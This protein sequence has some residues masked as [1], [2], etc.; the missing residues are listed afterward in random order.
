MVKFRVKFRVTMRIRVSVKVKFKV[1]FE[2]LAIDNVS[3]C[4]IYL[5]R[6]VLVCVHLLKRLVCCPHIRRCR[7]HSRWCLLELPMKLENIGWR[8]EKIERCISSLSR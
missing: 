4:D 3:Y 2:D 8:D 5:L 7:N 6:K 1:G